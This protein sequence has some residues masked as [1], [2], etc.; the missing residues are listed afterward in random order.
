MIRMKSALG[1]GIGVAAVVA[2]VGSTAP[3]FAEADRSPGTNGT[4]S[5]IGL[6]ATM[7][8]TGFDRTVAEANGYRI[9]TDES[10]KESSVPVSEE[11][12]RE[13]TAAR[14]SRSYADGTCGRASLTTK[15]VSARG[16]SQLDEP[17]QVDQRQYLHRQSRPELVVTQSP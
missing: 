9:V 2:V 5:T 11:A 16:G 10:G 12:Q 8:V 4:T 14:S 3:A 1:L 13:E 6:E 17:R 7:V 15:P